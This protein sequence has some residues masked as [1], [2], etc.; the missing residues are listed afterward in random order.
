MSEAHWYCSLEQ[1]RVQKGWTGWDDHLQDDIWLLITPAAAC[2][3][4]VPL[5]STDLG[6][7]WFSKS[8]LGQALSLMSHD[9]SGPC[10]WQLFPGEETRVLMLPPNFSSFPFLSST[11]RILLRAHSHSNPTWGCHLQLPQ[12]SFCGPSSLMGTE[13]PPQTS[14]TQNISIHLCTV[15]WGQSSEKDQEA[16]CSG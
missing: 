11:T 8:G 4:T 5:I 15:M 16:R 14:Q 10:R 6:S 7:R 12:S 2:T 13:R 3:N 1:L 9:E